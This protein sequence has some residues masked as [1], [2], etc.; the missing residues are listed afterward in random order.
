MSTSPE[1]IL[2][3]EGD[4]EVSDLIA[5]QALQPM[6]FKV[7]VISEGPQAIQAAIQFAPEVMIVNLNLPGLS[8][9]DLLV[10]LTSQGIKI[11]V[12]V[13]AEKGM[14]R[15]VI[16]AFRLGASD[17]LGWPIREAEVVSAVERALTQVR[18][19]KEREQ[20]ARKLK[21]TNQELENRIRELTTIFSI[22]KAVT[23]INDPQ[24]LFEKIIEGAVYV[25]RADK[26][27]LLLKNGNDNVFRLKAQKNLPKSIVSQLGKAWDD[28]ISSLVGLSGETLTIYG[29]P[30]KRF[31]VARL[32][33]SAL[34]VPVK[35]HKEVVGLMVVMREAAKPFSSGNQTLLEALAD[36]VSISLI[37]LS[38]FQA[39]EAQGRAI[40]KVSGNSSDTDI[41]SNEVLFNINKSLQSPLV[42]ISQEIDLL[43]EE[44][45]T[46]LDSKSQKSV[47]NIRA[48][49]ESVAEISKALQQFA[50]IHEPKDY[51]ML[52][53]VDIGKQVVNRFQ[54]LAQKNKVKLKSDL[55]AK[56]VFASAHQ[57]DLV[58]VF[59]ALLTNAIRVSANGKVKL[60]VDIDKQGRPRVIVSDTGP[61]I[62][63]ADQDKIFI[64]FYPVTSETGNTA[65]GF[66][67]GLALAREIVKNHNGSLRIKSQPKKGASFFFTLPIVK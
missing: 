57:G 34:V 9:K 53:L 17:Y 38:L 32:G 2:L 20:L 46:R 49:L 24:K 13:I 48:H 29:D 41:Y 33:Q 35:A 44:K 54:P 43:L 1:K 19:R 11:P 7:K 47:L 18:A 4:P 51:V 6:G 8:G 65:S 30:L 23:S 16:Q 67:I 52:N 39:V 5:R 27:W 58:L 25:A 45:E 21:S 12:I 42:L 50:K 56:P 55:S 31:K 64:P 37:N 36:Y 22:G 40:H 66:G 15:D 10:A 59:E 26:G 60:R 14:E 61:G 62:D 28:G 3:V 63:P